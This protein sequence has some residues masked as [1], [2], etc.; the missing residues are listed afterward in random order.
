MI[1]SSS[2][3]RENLWR[4]FFTKR[5]DWDSGTIATTLAYYCLIPQLLVDDIHYGLSLFSLLWVCSAL[6]DLPSEIN[7]GNKAAL[8]PRFCL[9]TWAKAPR[10]VG[11]SLRLCFQQLSRM[12]SS[13]SLWQQWEWGMSLQPMPISWA[14]RGCAVSTCWLVPEGPTPTLPAVCSG[15]WTEEYSFLSLPA[16]F[17]CYQGSAAGQEDLLV[18]LQLCIKFPFTHQSELITPL[19]Y[20]KV[21]QLPPEF[22]AFILVLTF[23][24]ENK[25]QL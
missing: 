10:P 23:T 12:V 17:C 1:D 8:C 9:S 3:L 20:E 25:L 13:T 7:K 5:Q 18:H 14:H 6:H 4:Y 11:Q 19:K 16:G 2:R 21:Y 15:T 24:Q 22:S